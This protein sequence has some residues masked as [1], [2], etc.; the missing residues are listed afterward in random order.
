MLS[1][2]TAVPGEV[3]FSPDGKLFVVTQKVDSTIGS[4]LMCFR[5]IPSRIDTSAHV[6]LRKH[7]VEMTDCWLWSLGF[8]S[9]SMPGVAL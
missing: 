3:R 6:L 8:L 9:S 7:F 2:P 4:T 5:A 1:S